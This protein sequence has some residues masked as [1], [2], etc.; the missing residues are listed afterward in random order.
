MFSSQCT[1]WH[2]GIAPRSVPDP[3]STF[4]EAM[5]STMDSENFGLFWPQL[6]SVFHNRPQK[7]RA[8]GSDV[9]LERNFSNHTDSCRSRRELSNSNY[10][11]DVR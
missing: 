11:E 6:A 5:L 10:F 4:Q 8:V 1:Q 3:D 7:V 9:I 2:C